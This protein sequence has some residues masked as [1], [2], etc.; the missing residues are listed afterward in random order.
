MKV[1][2]KPV[3]MIAAFDE[4][5]FPTPLRFK[6]EESDSQYRVVKVDKIISTESI[7]P[8]GMESIVFLCQSEVENIMKRYE[9]IYRVKAHQWE[10]YKI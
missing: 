3:N 7:K 2:A 10:L 6:I 5:G 1:I 9:L 8:A 4:R